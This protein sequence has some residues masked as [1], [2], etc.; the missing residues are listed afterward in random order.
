MQDKSRKANELKNI[1][2]LYYQ[3]G[4]KKN[5]LGIMEHSMIIKTIKTI[6]MTVSVKILK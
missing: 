3:E 2:S 4:L 6:N 1:K 5:F